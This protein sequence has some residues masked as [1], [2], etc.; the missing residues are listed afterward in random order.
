[1]AAGYVAVSVVVAIAALMV[2]LMVAR[3][4]FGAA[5]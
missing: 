5:L 3:R 1:M 2:G 4:A